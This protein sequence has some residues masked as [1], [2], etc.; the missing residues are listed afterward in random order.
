MISVESQNTVHKAWMLRVLTEVA[1]DSLLS[2]QL[3]FKGGT[4][5]SMMGILNRFSV[6]LDFDVLDLE[7]TP[8]I[9][10]AFRAI[11]TKLDLSI[12]DESKNVVEFFVKYPAKENTR[13]ILKIDAVVGVFKHA[14]N[15]PV[16]LPEISRTLMCQT[17]ETIFSHKL[18]ALKERYDKKEAIA[19]RDLYD[20]HYFFFQG[21][22]Y[23][24]ELIKERTN[25]TPISY[26]KELVDFIENKMDQE[27]I[28]RD[29]NPLLLTK[30]FHKVRRVLKREAIL[31]L[32]QEIS[33]LSNK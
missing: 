1:E 19:G 9:R 12:K 17:K 5:A 20:I 15:T 32:N 28:D 13:S 2:K 7:K 4:C 6:D 30:E 8:D 3:I 21:L 23:I 11:F 24:P 27:S 16:Y 33:R 22:R 18:V 31:F 25:K 29:L 14:I 26:F 10:K